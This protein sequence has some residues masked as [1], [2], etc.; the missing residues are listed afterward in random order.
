MTD[1]T[2]ADHGACSDCLAHSGVDCWIATK[3]AV[4]NDFPWEAFTLLVV[5]DSNRPFIESLE[6]QALLSQERITE[7][8]IVPVWQEHASSDEFVSAWC[9]AVR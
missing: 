3:E 7:V 5:Y 1:V 8:C 6:L 2:F 4:R 9:H